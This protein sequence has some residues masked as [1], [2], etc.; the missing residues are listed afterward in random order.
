[1]QNQKLFFISLFVVIVPLYAFAKDDFVQAKEVVKRGFQTPKLTTNFPSVQL[2]SI[3]DIGPRTYSVNFSTS[4]KMTRSAEYKP[5]NEAKGSPMFHVK[6]ST[7]V[8]DLNGTTMYKSPTDGYGNPTENCIGIE[9]GYS[10]RELAADST[11]K[12]PHDVVIRNGVLADFDLGIIVHTGV[13]NVTF[14]DITIINSVIGCACMGLDTAM[15]GGK[16]KVASCTFKNVKIVGQ[17]AAGRTVLV[18]G[19]APLDWVKAKVENSDS[20]GLNGAALGYGYG[21]DVFMPLA[22]NSVADDNSAYVYA[23]IVLDYVENVLLSDVLVSDFGFDGDIAGSAEQSVVQAITIKDS[24]SVFAEGIQSINHVSAMSVTS[25]LLNNVTSFSCKHGVFGDNIVTQQEAATSTEGLHVV[26]VHAQG[27]D[28]LIFDDLNCNR[29]QAP[30]KSSAMKIEN[31]NVVTVS[32]VAADYNEA[33]RVHGMLIEGVQN[34]NFKACSSSYNVSTVTGE[35]SS[36]MNLVGVSA[37]SIDDCKFRHNQGG[38]V[39]GLQIE[40]GKSCNIKNVFADYNGGNGKVIGLYADTDVRSLSIDG[41]YCNNNYST[42]DDVTGIHMK[43]AEAVTMKNIFCNYNA[44][45]AAGGNIVGMM[46]E[47]VAGVDVGASTLDAAHIEINNN[48]S[49]VAAKTVQG[50]VVQ[51]GDT[52][53][54]KDVS[55]SGNNG[56]SDVVGFDFQTRADGIFLNDISID[57]NK[58]TEGAVKGIT[59]TQILNA[60]FSNISVSS[61]GTS[62]GTADVYGIEI[63]AAHAVSFSDVAINNN[64]SSGGDMYALS[65]DAA[66]SLNIS[67]MWCS[68]N[69]SS[70][71]FNAYGMKV[72]T[73][74]RDAEISGVSCTSNAGGIGVYGIDVA[75]ATSV[76]LDNAVLSNNVASQYAR[77]LHIDGGEIITLSNCVCDANQILDSSIAAENVLQI[78]DISKHAPAHFDTGA[79]GIYLQDVEG[80]VCSGVEASRNKGLRAGGIVAKNV[81]EAS[82]VKCSTSYQSA[83][84]AFFIDNPFDGLIM[85]EVAVPD[86]QATTIFGGVDLGSVVDLDF[87]IKNLFLSMTSLKELQDQCDFDP[88][89][90]VE[91]G[92]RRTVAAGQLI[93]R[94]IM[95]QFRRYG[96]AVGMHLH[97][98]IN[99]YLEDHAAV[100][101]VSLHDSAI[102]LVTTGKSVGHVIKGGHFS[103][104]NGWKA[105]ARQTDVSQS[106]DISDVHPLWQALGAEVLDADDSDASSAIPAI[107]TS[108]NLARRPATM[109]QPYVHLGRLVVTFTSGISPYYELV[110][111][112]GGMG[113]GIVIGDAAEN[114]E[115]KN[116]V[117]ANNCGNAGQAY[118]I[119][120]DVTTSLTAHDN[121]IYQNFVNTLGYGF[122]IAEMSLQSNSVHAGNIMFANTIENM[123]NANF[124]V[125]YDPTY[126]SQ[127][128][129]QVKTIHNGDFS[130]MANALPYDNIEIEFINKR[131]DDLYVSDDVKSDWDA[132]YVST[133]APMVI[134]PAV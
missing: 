58:S 28:A 97:D 112:T 5:M 78:G 126:H 85:S 110:N 61:N 73:S 20:T 100:G 83:T 114:I 1:M 13:K 33:E 121:Q 30:N 60:D 40:S 117:C 66:R 69:Q 81:V 109:E 87:A 39:I 19:Q 10:P 113:A 98:S 64:N 107:I 104:N 35:F 79:Y 59:S 70:A 75:S 48:S 106:I 116:C 18:G 25:L 62:A 74:L 63:P 123:L 90:T 46:F 6:S 72:N 96:T 36:A 77:G 53:N 88:A 132:L 15:S 31:G 84:G 8:L 89:S 45:T 52:N 14:E 21:A 115:I 111:V 68:Y 57:G 51:N 22:L 16:G 130:V 91:Y 65:F 38:D 43:N 3:A 9:V 92:Y 131:P 80:I 17:N 93:I 27:S 24:S 105:S 128:S 76:I 120:Q 23:G 44:T 41:L 4:L 55:I 129:F 11:L 101:N 32:N 82:F 118:G 54:F 71:D 102:G 134:P 124:F 103:G 86:D 7:V 47:A 42:A 49:Q 12:Q 125:P 133:G 127:L 122:G 37:V 108:D 119:L 67:D 29:N 99:C 94:A 34:I 95:A 50:I 56:L 26:G 2:F